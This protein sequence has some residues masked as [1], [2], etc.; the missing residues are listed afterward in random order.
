MQD[1]ALKHSFITI[2]AGIL[3]L[4]ALPVAAQTWEQEV[5]LLANDGE[6][7]DEF[8]FAVAI[9]GDTALIG[10][11]GDDDRGSGT[12]AVYVY[13]RTGGTWVQ[14]AKLLADDGEGLDFF[15]N[16]VALSGDTAVIGAYSDTDSGIASGSAYVFV[17]NGTSWVQQA[18]LL[19]ND[20]ATWDFFGWS[21]ALSGDTALI[22]VRSDDDLGQGSGSA[23]VF[24][25]NGTSWVQQAKLLANDG[26]AGE[27]FGNSVALSGDTA[28]IHA[29][30]SAEF[31]ASSAVYVFMRNG[32][33]WV[34]DAKLTSFARLPEGSLA[35]SGDTVVIGAPVDDDL[36]S[37][38]GSAYVFVRDGLGNWTQQ[39]KLL[40]NDGAEFDGFGNSVA[41]SG[42]T[43][44]IGADLD[45]DL[46]GSSG[47]AYVFVRNGTS[48]VQQAKLLA[49]DGEAYE[50]FGNTAAL[51]GDTAVFGVWND[52][53]LGVGSGSAYV[54]ELIETDSDGDGV[55]DS[56]DAFPS[57]PTEWDDTDGDGTGNNAD[58]DDDGDGVPDTEDA[59]PL[60]Q[61][62]DA[63][64]GS[65]AFSFIEALSRAGITAGCGGNNYCPMAPVTRAQMAVFLERGMNGS[66]FSPPPASGNVFLD[67]GAQ[68][69]A[70]SFIEQLATDG[71]TAGC[72][73][74]NYC[75]TAEITRDQMA[76]FL[77]RAKYGS[78]YSPL[79]ATGVFNDVPLGH[80]A[81]N[82]IEQLA[83]EGITAGCGN[84]NYCPDA[85]VTRDQMAVFLVRTFGL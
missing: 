68:D 38:A 43:A 72:G 32:T 36:G 47:S 17:R 50:Y 62:A 26:F 27:L 49:N 53:D 30:G 33:S 10:A 61:F 24:V 55:P 59:Y 83:A 2:L 11:W 54:F 23:Y 57:D 76:V 28:I 65:F 21:V 81:G 75:P 19:A 44:V 22:G 48:W 5:K 64:P 85:V 84:G 25:R 1:L 51:S 69:F 42:D 31:D 79:P 80:W 9:S 20:R 56:E 14:Q 37:N 71:I 67:V 34:Q 12:G 3:L 70:A 8:G 18:K 58:L 74:N 82:W 4:S 45:D 63:P 66:A 77:L 73:N 6:T 46:G 7:G 52:D 39:A 16:S 40:A 35:V 60:G 29:I 41:V 78:A 13:I 15:G